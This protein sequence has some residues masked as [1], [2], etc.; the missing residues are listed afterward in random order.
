MHVYKILKKIIAIFLKHLFVHNVSL[1]YGI[2]SRDYYPIYEADIRQVTE[3]NIEDAKSF[4][5]D[6]YLC[7]FREF[8]NRGDE[9]YYA[10]INEKCAHRSWV[11]HNGIMDVD[12]FYHR[13]LQEN[14]VFIHWCET[15]VW[16][17][18]K[19]LYPA[20]LARIIA[21]HPGKRV[22]ISV[23]EKNM[24]SRRGIEKAGFKLQER[25][26]TMVVL[27]MKWTSV[28]NMMSDI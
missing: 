14:E 11:P 10:Y 4:Q 1:L 9:G 23:N 13:P 16:A 17:R 20:T 15:A 25:V 26:T 21:D 6:H 2:D 18:G 7:S 12:S 3:D 5:A 24:A 27:G 19:N 8:L 22:C 28:K